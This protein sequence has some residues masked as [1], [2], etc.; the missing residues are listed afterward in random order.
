MRRAGYLVSVTAKANLMAGRF[1]FLAFA[2]LAQLQ[3]ATAVIDNAYRSQHG[4][5]KI[6]PELPSITPPRQIGIHTDSNGTAEALKEL[7]TSQGYGFEEWECTTDDGYILALHRIPPRQPFGQTPGNAGMQKAPAVLLQH[8][9]FD[10]SSVWVLNL[11]SQSLGFLLSDRGYDVWMGN[12]RGNRYSKRHTS[13]DPARDP[14]FWNFS[15]SDM[16]HHDLP[17]FL[18][19]IRLA[20]G[21]DKVA[22]VGHSQGTTQMFVMQALRLPEASWVSVF[23]ALAPAVFLGNTQSPMIRSLAHAIELQ[24]FIHTDMELLPSTAEGRKL[25]PDLCRKPTVRICD[26]ILSYIV[27]PLNY[28]RINNTRMPLY[29]AFCP[30]GSSLKDMFHFAQ[31]LRSPNNSFQE[32]DCNTLMHPSCNMDVYGTPTPPEFNLSAIAVPV[33]TLW[34]GQDHLCVPQ[35]AQKLISQL[36]PQVLLYEQQVEEYQHLDFVW[37]IDAHELVYPH[38]FAA[39]DMHHGLL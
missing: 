30:A 9:V 11:P 35:D 20:T 26:N 22:Y 16:A 34:G 1:L 12:N 21:Q 18:R 6:G 38:V 7:V 5:R 32:Y 28:E 37:A 23:V 8:G 36:P 19:T 24:R 29:M 31:E 25:L 39:L 27:G 4:L 15:F 10:S 2:A 33:V 14:A 3:V 13:L 17:A